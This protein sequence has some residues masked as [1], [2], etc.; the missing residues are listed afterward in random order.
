MEKESNMASLPAIGDNRST[1]VTSGKL[2]RIMYQ[3][4]W[5]GRRVRRFKKVGIYMP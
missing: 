5:D 2:N 1:Y 4:R 3:S